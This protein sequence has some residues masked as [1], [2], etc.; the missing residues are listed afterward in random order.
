MGSQKEGVSLYGSQ[1]ENE[2]RSAGAAARKRKTSLGKLEGGRL[3]LRDFR[4]GEEGRASSDSGDQEKKPKRTRSVG[5]ASKPLENSKIEIKK[6][7][8]WRDLRDRNRQTTVVTTTQKDWR[9]ANSKV[10]WQ[11][12]RDRSIF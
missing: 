5:T 7:L 10:E 9:P 12:G 8:W 6:K 11:R 4:G 1:K 3:E 2:K